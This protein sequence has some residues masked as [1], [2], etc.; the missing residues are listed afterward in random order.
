MA[1]AKRNERGIGAAQVTAA[2]MGAYAGL[3]GLIHGIC[4]MMQGF[5]APEGLVFY[6]M[7]PPCQPDAVWHGCLPAMTLVPSLFIAGLVTVMAGALTVIWAVFGVRRRGGSLGLI[8][9]SVMMLLT[10]GGFVAPYT[11]V[12]AGIAALLKDRGKPTTRVF[13]TGLWP[14]PLV[15]LMVWFPASW[16]A[17]FFFG[18]AMLAAG[19][20]LFVVF[21]ILLPVLVLWTG[22]AQDR[23]ERAE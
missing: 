6:A 15:L 18:E 20:V 11:G 23:R 4:E 12:L 1:W 16:I 21:D 14:W 2:V 3:L 7:G 8:L 13:P 22:Q 19:P 9:L 10:G 5:T 17:G